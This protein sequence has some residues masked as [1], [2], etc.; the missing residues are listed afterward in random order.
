[1]V[2]N[3]GLIPKKSAVLP[4]KPFI[5]MNGSPKPVIQYRLAVQY[6]LGNSRT[7][8]PKECFSEL[9]LPRKNHFYLMDGSPDQP[10]VS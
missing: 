7:G 5:L 1:M 3:T 10:C 8:H 6:C 2:F 9:A 4:K